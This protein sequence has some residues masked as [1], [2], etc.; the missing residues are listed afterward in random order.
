MATYTVNLSG[1]FSDYSYARINGTVYDGEGTWTFASK[2]SI[3]VYVSSSRS[4]LRSNC[5]VTLNGTTVKNGYGSYTVD[6][7]SA[8]IINIQFTRVQSGSYY[9]FT[10]DITTETST[11]PDPMAPHDGH[12]TNIGQVARQIEAGTV[13]FG[14]VGR[15]IESGLLLVGGVSRE[16]SIIKP[17]TIDITVT[18]DDYN[19]DACWLTIDGVKYKETQTIEVKAGTEVTFYSYSN[20][21]ITHT[22]KLDGA[23]VAT[24]SRVETINYTMAVEQSLS[25]TLSVFY[26]FGNNMVRGS[27]TI[28]TL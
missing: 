2:P 7:G 8:D 11:P 22:I 28:T 14:G 15:E 24:S 23:T 9:Y 6:V 26:S 3:E 5:K 16:I 25:V 18:G 1:F 13:L 12:N 10:C 4:A 17:L 20:Y 19:G 21:N 27:V